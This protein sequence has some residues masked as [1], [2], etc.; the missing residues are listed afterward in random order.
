MLVVHGRSLLLDWSC[1]VTSVNE[2]ADSA[3]HPTGDE[4][5]LAVQFQAQVGMD[6]EAARREPC[7][8]DQRRRDLRPALA[9]AH[10]RMEPSRQQGEPDLLIEGSHLWHSRRPH[11]C[12]D[13]TVFAAHF[14]GQ[15]GRVFAESRRYF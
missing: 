13:S 9:S 3:F 6:N 1:L 15:A 4:E 14:R 11:G 7:E 12:H 5:V 2:R 10:I 8:S